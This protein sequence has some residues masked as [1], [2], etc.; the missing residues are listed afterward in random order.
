MKK[1]LITLFVVLGLINVVLA[2]GTDGYGDCMMN[3][4]CMMNW[5]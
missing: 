2:D 4:G 1:L 3:W 5:E